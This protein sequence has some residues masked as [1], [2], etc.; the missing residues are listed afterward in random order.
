MS[1]FFFC[2]DVSSTGGAPAANCSRSVTTRSP[3]SCSS[4]LAVLFRSRIRLSSRCSAPTILWPSC[5]DSSRAVFSTRLAPADM[6]ISMEA[7]TR[8]RIW[9]ALST[10]RRMAS[11]ALS[12]AGKN[13]YRRLSSRS[14]PSRRCSTSSTPLPSRLASYLAKNMTRLAFS[15]NRSNMAA[16]RPGF[17]RLIIPL[18]HGAA[19]QGKKAPPVPAGRAFSLAR[20]GRPG[21]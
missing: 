21:I 1:F 20:M 15:V 3:F 5:S 16:P 4:R 11:R 2:F 10:P 7:G 18:F 13:R 17:G 14:S 6:G 12:P 8:S 9:M 19:P